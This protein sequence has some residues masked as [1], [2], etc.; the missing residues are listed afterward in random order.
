MSEKREFLW[1]LNLYRRIRKGLGTLYKN[2]TE[3]SE[4]EHE[5]RQLILTRKRPA[6]N[7]P[8]LLHMVQ[9]TH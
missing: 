1:P 5:M 4:Q 8:L 6:L 7:D 2:L 9:Y 3:E